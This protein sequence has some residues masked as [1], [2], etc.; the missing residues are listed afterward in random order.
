MYRVNIVNEKTNKDSYRINIVG[1]KIYLNDQLFEW[2]LVE[3]KKNYFH[4]LKNNKSYIVEIVAIDQDKKLVSVKLNGEIYEL[5]V[6]NK[7]D[8]LLDKLGMSHNNVAKLQEIKAPM[9]GLILKTLVSSGQE[10][11]KGESVMILEAMKMEN[12]IK[13]PGEGKVKDILVKVGDSVEKNTL[14]VKF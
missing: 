4:L 6:K 1:D 10:V 8:L 12:V 11:K 13:S 2:D 3:V 14:L 9:P 5:S 7:L